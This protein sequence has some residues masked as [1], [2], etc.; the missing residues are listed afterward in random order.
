ML[1]GVATSRELLAV[2]SHP[3]AVVVDS[4]PAVPALGDGGKHVN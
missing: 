3:P 2:K 1:R 4:G